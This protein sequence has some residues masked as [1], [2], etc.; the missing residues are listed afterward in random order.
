ME[1]ERQ[2]KSVVKPGLSSQIHRNLIQSSCSKKAACNITMG[3]YDKS[4]N[5]ISD[6]PQQ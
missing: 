4:K 2:Q 3:F 1:T 5:N 6:L